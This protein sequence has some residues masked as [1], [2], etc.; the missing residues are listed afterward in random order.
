MKIIT[1]KTQSK[2][3]NKK[4]K[5]LI[6]FSFFVVF[7][8]SIFFIFRKLRNENG[9]EN[10]KD[11]KF[12]NDNKIKNG[13][14]NYDYYK[15]VL[16]LNEDDTIVKSF[17][18]TN[19]NSSHIRYHFQDLYENRK[20]FQ[21]NYNYLPYTQID[22]QK[23]FEENAKNI[24]ETTG[25][26]NLTKLNIYYNNKN[27]DT[28]KF[29][30]IHLAM[31]FNKDY[32]V[33]SVISMA[34]ILKTSSPDTYIHFH[35]ALLSDIQY[36]DL[37]IIIDLNKINENVEF[38]FYNSRQAEYDF[39]EKKAKGG[40]GL[41]DY[42]R[43]LLPEIVNNTNRIIIMDSAD[44]IVQKDLSELY[45]FDI[46]N[47]YFAFA[48]NDIAGKL[49][50]IFIFG[51]NKFYSNTGICLVN[52]RKFR[53]DNLYR[54]AF[55]A[56]MAYEDLPCPYQDILFMVSNYKFKY[57]PLNYNCPQFFSDDEINL[58][59]FNSKNMKFWL[60]YQ[61][62]SPFRYSKEEMLEASK[63]PVIL[64]LY[65]NKPFRNYANSNNTLAWINYAKMAGVYN[66]M[67]NK[68]P[69]VFKRFNLE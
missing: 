26:L 41:G 12:E 40:R 34:S 27:I 42:T 63:N 35:L 38:V 20:I 62:N 53:E 37:K 13:K 3:S 48:L 19:Y 54:N 46:G 67:K 55:F 60:S 28:S 17:T 5:F 51:R 8:I 49:H 64:H 30:H 4:F 15:P 11:K 1:N 18:K 6:F 57:W 32:I 23:S 65:A 31:G 50:D 56:T 43:I 59:D 61:E 7:V 16:P 29:N 22:K 47:N 10:E 9:S 39:E 2:Q 68:Y 25:L 44:I 66:E 58:K 21:I 33:L 24:Y 69:N 36:E 14:F 45:F 52:I